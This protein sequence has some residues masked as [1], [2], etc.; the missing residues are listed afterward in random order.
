MSY[1]Q[2]NDDYIKKLL[3]V[4][5]YDFSMAFKYHFTISENK[6]KKIEDLI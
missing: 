6:K 3:I 4:C 5:N 2:F 1:G